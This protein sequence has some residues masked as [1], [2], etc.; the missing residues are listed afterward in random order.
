MPVPSGFRGMRGL[1]PTVMWALVLILDLLAL[2]AVTGLGFDDGLGRVFAS[3]SA[4]NADYRELSGEFT[5]SE[6][7]TVVV[8]ESPDFADPDNLQPVSDFVIETSFLDGVVDVFSVF[9]LREP[10]EGGVGAPLIGIDV[11]RDGSLAQTLDDI[12]GNTSG[13]RLVSEGRKLTAVVI[14]TDSSAVIDGARTIIGELETIATELTA[15][16]DV[17]Y[18]LTG[19]PAVRLDIVDSLFSD[20]IRL[21]SLGMI[22]GFA[23]CVLALRSIRLAFLVTLPAGT[24]LLWS[25]GALSIF[26]FGINVL[27]IALP[28]L[29]L[30]LA[31]A[32]SLHLAFEIRRLAP[33]EPSPDR[34]AIL[35]LKRVGPACALASF[36]TAIA[37]GGLMI[38]ESEI[39]RDFGVAGIVAALIAL[40]AVL[41]VQPLV[42]ATAGRF[43][44]AEKLFPP[45]R[46]A[47]LRVFDW[48]FLPEFGLRYPKPIAATAIAVLIAFGAVYT[49]I[50]PSYSVLENINRDAPR[51][52]AIETLNNELAPINTIDIPVAVDASNGL[53]AGALERVAATHEAVAGLIPG[54]V[55]VSLHSLVPDGAEL[56]PAE[57]AE[58]LSRIVSSMSANQRGRVLSEDGTTAL[59]RLHI[60]TYDAG[61]IRAMTER[62]EHALAADPIASQAAGTPTGFMV[63]SSFVS[64]GMILDLNY[65]FFIAVVAS[66]LLT[67]LWF[68]NWRYGAVALVPNVLPILAV[69]AWLVLSGRGLQFS[70]GVALTIA[71]GIAVD[72][73]VHIINRLRINAPKGKPFDPG[74]IH[75]SVVEVTP[76][77][78][79]TTAVLSFGLLSTFSSA[80]PMIGYFGVLSIAVF[81]LAIFA[82][83]VVLPA[84][85]MVLHGFEQKRR[86]SR[87]LQEG[88]A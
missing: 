48:R 65:C 77:L 5:P 7:D 34:L 22:A 39:V 68:A 20:L 46:K 3:D 56:S 41:T 55:T 57:R 62:I 88:D 52:Q 53:D 49:A 30:V 11:P 19:L 9:A 6:G 13:G 69:G 29:I 51:V 75:R 23:I 2:I 47:M 78:V 33:D 4:R 54:T 8:F 86:E 31:F 61:E 27:S 35:A 70:S 32:D 45:R 87:I 81:I 16:T 83:L 25:L 63:M 72:D 14:A 58:R 28:V 50:E 17:S 85:L 37:F 73:T 12:A 66:G 84:C 1:A 60:N 79:V 40:V 44:P 82:D 64:G 59:V 38:S 26:G 36:T 42:F 74:A 71:F 15:G 76:A 10:T 24:A 80:S 18:T 43:V 21:N 67:T